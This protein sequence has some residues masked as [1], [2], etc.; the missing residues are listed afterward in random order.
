MVS[1]RETAMAA[2]LA[3]ISLLGLAAHFLFSKMKLPGLLGMLSVGILLGPHVLH[4]MSPELLAVSSDFREIALIVILLRAGFE[5]SR[6]TLSKVGRTALLMSFIPATL[7]LLAVMTIAPKLLG[8]TVMEAA[9]L[10]AVLGAVSPAVVV[11][12]MI[13]LQQRRVGTD[14]G[15]PTL[16]IAASSVDDVY[17]IVIFTSLLGMYE[18]TQTNLLRNLAGIPVSI[19]LGIG[20][21][22]GVGFLLY[23]L[24]TR[25]HLRDT[26]KVVVLISVAILLTALESATKSLVPVSGLLA[27]MAVGVVLLEKY[28]ILVH[29]LSGKFEKIW[30]VAQLLLFVLVGAQVDISVAWKTGLAGLGVIFGALVFRSAGVWL[31]LLG[32]GLSRKEKGFCVVAY[33]PKATVQAAIGAVPLA[34]GVAAGDVILAVAVLSILFTAPLGAWGMRFT[35]SRWLKK[36]NI[37]HRSVQEDPKMAHDRAR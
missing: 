24:F 20:L 33:L 31:S 15:I 23:H 1:E 26:Q 3:I 27:V 2:S 17:V 4:R 19:L 25:F 6:K 8:I 29:R 14:K 7:E 18:G 35:H 12:F 13:E 30:V 22:I 37:A 28:E 16:L 11:P 10:G 21:G 34:A 36:E 5:M 9:I 32:S